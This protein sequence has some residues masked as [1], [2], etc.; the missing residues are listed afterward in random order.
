M[1]EKDISIIEPYC[2]NEMSRLK[3]IS[4]AI[5]RQLNDSVSG[6][7]YNDF[8]SLANL[9][10]WQA[11]KSYDPALSN[12]FYSYLYGCIV[13]KFKQEIRDRHRFK[14]VGNLMAIS[15][16]APIE[17]DDG[18][19]FYISEVIPSDFDTFKEAVHED[20]AGEYIARLSALQFKILNL[21]LD[22]YTS[23]EI[24]DILQISEREY[25][26]QLAEMRSFENVKY[27]RSISAS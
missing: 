11:Y 2:R 8:Y 3:G 18:N 4:N 17:R 22:G 6:V 10:L 19:K 23:G 12:S 27:L 20:C 7:D 13:R 15:L 21:L 24:R 25:L 16:D 14:R 9:T 5:L 1:G 26:K